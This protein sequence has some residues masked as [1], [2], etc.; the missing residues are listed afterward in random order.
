MNEELDHI[1]KNNT[2]ELVPRQKNK[3]LISTKWVFLNKLNE[4]GQVTRNKAILVCK[5]YTHIEGIDFE[6]T[7]APVS[8]M[9]S[10]RLIVCHACSKIIK[11]YQMDFKSNFLNVE[12]EEVVYNEQLEGFLLSEREDY[13]FR[14]K[15]PFYGLKKS[16]RTWYSRLDKYLQ[17]QGFMKGN[18]DKNLYIMVDRESILIIEFYVDHIIFGSDDDRMSHKFL[19][20]V[21]NEFKMYLLSEL[22][23]F[24]GLQICQR[25][26]G[27]FISQTKY[28]CCGWEIPPID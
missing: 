23:L 15:K 2:W 10:I 24:L 25:D 1:E 27:I 21:K 3:N 7:F 13:I 11:V 6:E 8:K 17:Q 9:E 12:L 19:R 14:M 26:K 20:D 18:A 5:G 28:I 4:D 22:N 16:P